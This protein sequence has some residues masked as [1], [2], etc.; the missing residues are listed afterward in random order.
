MS[1]YFMHGHKCV[2]GNKRFA[3]VGKIQVY[4]QASS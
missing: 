1:G 2:K 3:K 4:F